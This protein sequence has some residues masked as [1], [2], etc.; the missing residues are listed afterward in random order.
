MER[1]VRHAEGQK[2]FLILDNLRVHH[3]KVL[4]PWL[5]HYKDL[6]ELFFIPSYSPDLN[7]DEL[8]NH[9]LKAN[10]IGRKRARDEAELVANVKAHLEGRAATPEIVANFFKEEHVRYAA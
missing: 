6:I 3:A 4:Q 1:L 10:A 7:P 5:A 9:D 8:L 2:V